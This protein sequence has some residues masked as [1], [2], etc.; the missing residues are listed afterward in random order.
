MKPF[1]L[2]RQSC[3]RAHSWV[4]LELDGEL[5]PFERS[6][7]GAHLE[8]CSGC[9]T[10]RADVNALTNELR[11]APLEYPERPVLVPERRRSPF[12]ALQVSAAALAVVAV[13]LGSL[14]GS[15]RSRDVIPNGRL[16]APSLDFDARKM[17][18][19]QKQRFVRFANREAVER[20]AGNPGPQVF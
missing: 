16:A 12:R 5:S 1:G 14:I 7:L 9:R 17:R 15:L 8:Q 11:A 20:S 4:S 10:F 6:L 19:A 18:D 3:E 13:G 2:R